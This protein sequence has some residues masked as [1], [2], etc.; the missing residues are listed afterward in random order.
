MQ[1]IPSDTTPVLLTTVAGAFVQF[2]SVS[3]ASHFSCCQSIRGHKARR[4]LSYR[5]AAIVAVFLFVQVC[6]A[7]QTETPAKHSFL[8]W[9]NTTLMSVA[10]GGHVWAAKEYNGPQYT[11]TEVMELT[12]HQNF[13][14]HPAYSY[15]KEFSQM[16]MA[17]LLAYVFHRTNHHKMERWFLVGDSVAAYGSGWVYAKHYNQVDCQIQSAACKR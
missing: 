2:C 11:S 14:F 3:D 12:Y 8:D 13:S 1:N 17:T 9:K 10:A 5:K 7:Q 16:G 4:T 15:A 6:S